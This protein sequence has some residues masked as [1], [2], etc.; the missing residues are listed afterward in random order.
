MKF[1]GPETTMPLGAFRPELFAGKGVLVTGAAGGI[2]SGIARAFADLGARVVVTDVDRKGLAREAAG[3]HMS[4]VGGDLSVPGTAEK[5][6]DVAVSAAGRIDILVNNAGRSWGVKTEDIT[7][8]RTQ[9]LI[10]INLKSVLFLSRRFVMHARERQGGGSI[11][12]ISS[13]AG[14]VGFER[15]AVYT[16]TKFAVIGLTKVLALDHA[17]EDIRVNAILPHVVETEMFRTIAKREEIELWRAGIPM[18]R[19]ASVEDV[20]ALAIFLSSPA[21]AYLTGGAYAVDGG[22]MAGPYGGEA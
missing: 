2:G 3:S 9:E 6:F 19:F 8:E 20:A 13:T 1:S 4:V 12:Q 10:E 14:L 11:I 18:G 5:V 17:R 22:A 7:E 15:R 16:A 21:G